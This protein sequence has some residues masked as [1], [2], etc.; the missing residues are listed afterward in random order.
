M[1]RTNLLLLRTHFHPSPAGSF[2]WSVWS[3]WTPP[4]LFSSFRCSLYLSVKC[5]QTLA[6]VSANQVTLSNIN[7]SGE[8]LRILTLRSCEGFSWLLCRKQRLTRCSELDSQSPRA[9]DRK[10]T[11]HHMW[12]VFFVPLSFLRAPSTHHI[13]FLQLKCFGNWSEKHLLPSEK[14]RILFPLLYPDLD[15]SSRF[16]SLRF[17]ETLKQGS[18]H[19]VWNAAPAV[20][21]L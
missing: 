15:T 1:E 2:Y 12:W 13:S 17:M 3:L 5:L 20:F 8:K 6:H 19:G 14:L 4:S 11:W 10:V 21:L 16:C 9:A 18:L 7:H